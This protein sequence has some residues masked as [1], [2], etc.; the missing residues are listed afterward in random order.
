VRL[1]DTL[2]TRLTSDAALDINPAYSPDGRHIAFASDRSGRFEVWV[3][4]ADGSSQRQVASAGA[5]GH[6]VVWSSDSRSLVFRGEQERQMQ[7]YRVDIASGALTPLP[8]VSSGGHMSFSPAQSRIMDVRSHKVLWS[9][10][11][12]GT[13][14]L[15]VYQ[16]ADPDVRIDYPRWS[17]D[18]HWVVFDRAAPRGADLWT[19]EGF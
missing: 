11:L 9:H 7:I 1:R 5:W 18:G 12:D 14:P 4:S 10:P 2:L 15:Q 8:P 17:P 13:P 6:F 3:M 19:L 16:F